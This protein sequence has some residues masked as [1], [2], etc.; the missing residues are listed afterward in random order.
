ME[1]LS[2]ENRLPSG[3][4][5]GRE[6]KKEK[7]PEKKEERTFNRLVPPTLYSIAPVIFD[8]ILERFEVVALELRGGFFMFL[9]L[10][11]GRQGS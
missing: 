6:K 1:E 11:Q 8:D 9:C 10:S 3:R 2:A 7:R 5:R 4:N